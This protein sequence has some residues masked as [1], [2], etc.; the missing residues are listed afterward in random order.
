[1]AGLAGT[2]VGGTS[3]AT[4]IKHFPGGGA[5]ENGFDPHYAEGNG[6][7]TRPRAA[8]SAIT[9]RPFR[10]A[11]VSSSFMPYYSA[12]SIAKS[13]V[14]SVDGVEIPYEEVGFTFNHYVLHDLLRGQLG[15]TGY[16][17]LTPGS[18][19]T[20]RRGG[21]VDPR[22][23]A[24]AINAGT[25]L[26]ADTQQCVADLRAAVDRAG[27]AVRSPRAGL[28][29]TADRDVLPGIVRRHDVRRRRR[30]GCAGGGLSGLGTRR[31][32]PPGLEVLQ[33]C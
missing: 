4:T 2:A 15:F 11:P 28:C 6:T 18:P 30:G 26:I 14:Q 24:K 13:V 9:C 17:N 12:P 27:S 29:A 25:D 5:R 7:A 23:F 1:M 31:P 16:L 21:P 19:T 32:D 33:W 3:I 20:Q 8:S 22:A 10:A